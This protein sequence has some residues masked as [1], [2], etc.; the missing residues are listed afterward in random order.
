MTARFFI[1]KIVPRSVC[2]GSDRLLP[3][4]RGDRKFFDEKFSPPPPTRRAEIR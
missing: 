1:R 4:V 2:D 3:K